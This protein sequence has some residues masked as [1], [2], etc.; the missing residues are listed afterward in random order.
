MNIL[1]YLQARYS[2]SWNSKSGCCMHILPSLC[3]MKTKMKTILHF[4]ESKGLLQG[5]IALKGFLAGPEFGLSL[6]EVENAMG[7]TT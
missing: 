3:I 4:S 2:D 5:P 1:C 7:A 6:K